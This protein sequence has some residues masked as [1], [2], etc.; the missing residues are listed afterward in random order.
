MP[1]DPGVRS[2]RPAGPDVSVIIPTYNRLWSLPDAIAS[3]RDE[4]HRVEI[5]V[6]DD[7]SSDGTWEW[8]ADQAGIRAF[9]Q[10]NQGKVAA[11]NRGYELATGRFVRFLD[12]DDSLI[13]APARDQLDRALASDCDICVASYT[14]V[15]QES[16][17][18]IDHVWRDCGDF[19]AQQL[20]ECDSSHY[21]AYL[22]RRE[23]LADIRHRPE[24]SNRDD[25]MFVIE[26]AMKFPKVE[27]FAAPTFRHNHHAQDRIQFQPGSTAVVTDWQERRMWRQIVARLDAD[28]LLDPRRRLAMANN[29]WNLAKRTGAHFPNEGADLAR[30]L[31]QLAPD[32]V[33][34]D[35]GFDRLYRRLGY[36]PA[37]GIVNA[38]R[39]GRNLARRLLRPLRVRQ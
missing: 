23:F 14:A 35:E 12:S 25:R 29:V 11:V 15:Y 10:V 1:D 18:R 2:E 26:C 3:C 38:M 20:G 24:F 22:F 28:G 39:G 21:S 31:K 32:F 36:G 8:L 5:I 30:W 13:V 9:R 16:G 4:R 19:L 17:A 7:G 34:P 33:I 37:Q 27:G 6:V